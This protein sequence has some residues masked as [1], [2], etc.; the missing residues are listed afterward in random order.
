MDKQ[1][2]RY[3][4]RSTRFKDYVDK[5]CRKHRITVKEALGL[6]LTREVAASYQAEEAGRIPAGSSTYVP[7][8]ECV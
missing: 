6:A 7:M 3:Y 2:L 1:M 8:G 4:N 5:C